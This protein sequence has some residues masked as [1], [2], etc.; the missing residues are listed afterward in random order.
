VTLLAQ[1]LPTPPP[2]P[3]RENVAPLKSNP[4]PFDIPAVTG[5]DRIFALAAVQGDDAEIEMA[6]LAIRRTTVPEVKGFAQKMMTEHMGLADALLP[7][8][9]RALGG[10]LPAEKLAAPDMLAVAHLQT[11]ADVDVDQM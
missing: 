6:Q 8:L 1:V 4:A 9:T 7:A 10:T 3:L 2:A 11:L 5:I